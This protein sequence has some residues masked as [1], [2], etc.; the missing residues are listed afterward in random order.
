MRYLLTLLA[1]LVG[2]ARAIAADQDDCRIVE[3]RR[4]ADTGKIVEACTR[5]IDRAAGNK[6]EIALAHQARGNA[7]HAMRRYGDAVARYRKALRA[8][9]ERQ[10]DRRARE[11]R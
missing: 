2:V 11:P 1:L 4:G 9:E 5:L 7:L 8:W 6:D 3:E 10:R